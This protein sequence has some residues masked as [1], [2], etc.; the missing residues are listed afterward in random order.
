MILTPDFPFIQSA[1]ILAIIPDYEKL[2]TKFEAFSV[3]FPIYQAIWLEYF[4]FWFARLHKNSK[5]KGESD[6]VSSRCQSD[7]EALHGNYRWQRSCRIFRAQ[8]QRGYRH[9]SYHTLLNNG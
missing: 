3:F 9:L 4:L 2:T 1:K 8:V 5:Q 6:D 7:Y